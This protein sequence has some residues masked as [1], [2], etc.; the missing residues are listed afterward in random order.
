MSAS[1]AN[2]W[3]N[4]ETVVL[5]H[6]L[7][8]HGTVMHWFARRLRR[9]GYR[10]EVF[11]YRSLLRTPTEN[12][13]HL[14]RRLEQMTTP[15]V[16]LVGHSLGGIVLL[17]VLDRYADLKPGRLVLLGSPVKGSLV[18][19]NIARI[20]LLRQVLLGRSVHQG[21]LGGCPKFAGQREL[22][23]ICGDQP[24]GFGRLFTRTREPNDGTVLVRETRVDRARQ[25]LEIPATH[26]SLL[27]SSLAAQQTGRFLANG[28]FDA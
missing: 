12:A 28:Q 26:T 8:M 1:P 27:F 7:W 20:P 11:S 4:T 21:L 22:G 16:H 3:D 10:V 25:C 18:A 13:D 15:V 23:V 17:H 24:F 2:S 5:V 6:G 14:V 9:Q 19:A